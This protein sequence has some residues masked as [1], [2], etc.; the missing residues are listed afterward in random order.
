MGQFAFSGNSDIFDTLLSKLPDGFVYVKDSNV[1][2]YMDEVV[3][4]D[5]YNNYAVGTNVDIYI[6]DV[7]AT[8]TQVL[9][10]HSISYKTKPPYGKFKLRTEIA[11]QIIKEEYY[12]AINI[13]SFYVIIAQ[14][15]NYDFT[16]LF[17]LFGNL[18]YDTT[19]DDLLYKKYGW[20]F[21]I[22][23][24]SMDIDTYR[25]VVIGTFKSFMYS[26]V[27]KGLK[28]LVKAFI[29]VEPEIF[30]YRD[31]L[32]SYIRDT[33]ITQFWIIPK[34]WWVN[35]YQLI[36]SA[37]ITSVDVS[38]LTLT[39]RINSF[40]Q[41]L[42]FPPSIVGYSAII[43]YLQQVWGNFAI[44]VTGVSRVA[45][46]AMEI[47]IISGTSLVPL[48]LIAGTY[49]NNITE[50]YANQRSIFMSKKFEL[51]AIRVRIPTFPLAD[52]DKA[53]MENL[54]RKIVPIGT[55]VEVSYGSYMWDPLTLVSS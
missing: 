27:V 50:D 25:R 44:V 31:F 45:F 22:T 7:L 47:E 42:T 20:F 26:I 13:L 52:S 11:G 17:K 37:D 23:K 5:F 4:F 32:S 10:D 1:I 16:E 46:K 40:T 30:T 28:E 14:T 34:F 51:D 38:N 24:G 6:N 41:T 55:L 19:Q 33:S 15:I 18:Y 48:G 36:G 29:D 54:I 21:D 8:T 53:I 43:N 49:T 12:Y 3:Y 2:P 39:M 9:F 35:Q